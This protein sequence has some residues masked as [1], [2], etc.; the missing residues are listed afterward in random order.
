MEYDISE[1]GDQEVRLASQVTAASKEKALWL[2]EKLVPK[3]GINNIGS[4]IRVDGRLR[5]DALRTSIAI[6]LGRYEILRTVFIATDAELVKELVPVGEF[7]V[8]IEQIELSGG[9]LEKDLSAFVGRPFDLDGGPLLRAGLA[10]HPDGDIFCMAVHHLIFDGISIVIFMRALVPVYDAVAAGRPVSPEVPMDRSLREPEPRAADLTHWREKLHGFVPDRLDLWCDS[11]NVSHPLMSGEIVTHMLSAEARSAVQRLQRE[12]RAPVAAVLLAAYYAL[13][14]SHGAGP[15]LVVGSPLDVRGPRSSSAIGNHV[16]AVPLRLRVDFAEGFRQLARRARD[17]FLG[18]MAHAHVSVD[19][20][21]AELPRTGSAWQ[22]TLYRYLFNYLPEMDSSDFVI[23]GMTA[24]PLA[25]ENGFSKFDLELYVMPSRAEIR[26][27]YRTEILAPADVEALLRRYEG[28]LIAVA[29]DADRP[30][31]EL[32]GWSELDHK[33]IDAANETARQIESAT[34]MAAFRSR[35]LAS[36]EARAVVDD[37]CTLTYGRVWEAAGAVRDLLKSH[38]ISAGDVVAVVVP[39]SREVVVG[40]FGVWLAGATYLPLDAE[41]DASLLARLLTHSKAKA[42]LTGS[43]IRLKAGEGLPPVLPLSAAT[44]KPIA[45]DGPSKVDPLAPACLI[46]AREQAGQPVATLLS[47]QGI[48]NMVSHFARE[49]AVGPATGT[50]ALACFSSFGSLLELFL[51]LISGGRVIV[52]PDES[53]VDGD[54]LRETMER[55][56][57]GVVQVP[58]GVPARI[59]EDAG[60]RLS[61]LRIVARAEEMSPA[62]ARRLLAAG[63]Q[64]HGVYGGAETTGWAMSGRIDGEIGLT[65]GRPIANTRAFVVAPDGR[66]LPIG[67]R[68]ELCIAGSGIALGHQDDPRF[69]RSVQHGRHYRTGEL[70]RWRPD[71]T[72]ERLGQI[73]RQAFIAGSRVNL[74]EVDAVLLDRHGVSAAVALTVKSSSGG[75]ILVAFAEVSGEAAAAD[76]L[77]ERLR[78]HALASLPPAAVPQRVICVNALPRGAAGHVDH[79]A[80]A[81]L[82]LERLNDGFDRQGCGYR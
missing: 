10:A 54:A 29:Q 67:V 49:L 78:E 71:G 30:L 65:S 36:P 5:S 20:L 64:L 8:E 1:V 46:Y 38:G 16:N 70:A 59:L 4:A 77:A 33:T 66:E 73:R 28:I 24:R 31:G 69:P 74:S 14:A 11:P 68:G 15:D 25:I 12:V 79:D 53:Q 72:V 9:H 35:V 39:R 82:A 52:A 48:A 18:A 17:V 58:P 27:R 81:L 55:H 47:H 6:L 32:A 76:R 19:D 45:L 22:T 40:A 63:C 56:H 57:V 61:G 75:D 50:L 3:S 23:D 34:V 42:V 26:F 13:L 2:Q 60:D 44:A 62:L 43:G 51:P 41:Q 37:E 21:S 80:L 7:K